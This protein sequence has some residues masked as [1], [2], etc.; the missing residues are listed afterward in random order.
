MSSFIRTYFLIKIKIS[1]RQCLVDKVFMIHLE[2]LYFCFSLIYGPPYTPDVTHLM[3][4]CSPVILSSSSRRLSPR[5][6]VLQQYWHCINFSTAPN[7]I[8]GPFMFRMPACSTLSHSLHLCSH[9][10]LSSH[11]DAV[12]PKKSLSLASFTEQKRL[13]SLNVTL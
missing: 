13:Y 5:S 8:P 11:S 4:L 3:M 1:Y 12:F 7:S 10:H 2:Q 9:T 6:L